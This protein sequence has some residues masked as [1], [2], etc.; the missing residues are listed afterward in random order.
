MCICANVAE[1]TPPPNVKFEET[2]TIMNHTWPFF[3]AQ[4]PTAMAGIRA[5]YA[6]LF[7]SS[8]R[9]VPTQNGLFGSSA[10]SPSANMISEEA[11]SLLLHINSSRG[12]V[13]G[14]SST[15]GPLVTRQGYQ[16]F[17]PGDYMYNFELPLD[18]RLPETINAEFGSIKYELKATIARAGAFRVSLVGIKEVILIRIPVEGSLEQIEPIVIS[19][20]WEDQLRCDVVISG[21]LFPL[22]AQIPIAFK[23]TPL[24][25]GQCDYIKVFATENV[26]LYCSNKRVHRKEPVRKVQLFEKRVDGPPT[27]T[28]PG[29]FT[30]IVSGGGTPYK[31]K[32]LPRKARRCRCRNPRNY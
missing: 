28:F 15:S 22:A 29:C 2:D 31:Q 26:E 7:Q 21:K 14:D 3:D 20:S 16:T 5:D 32:R 6:N 11:N 18:S 8:S 19:R 23:L 27:S 4:F 30:R 17:N 1:G 12:F 9:G 24:A 10:N 25:K 13:K